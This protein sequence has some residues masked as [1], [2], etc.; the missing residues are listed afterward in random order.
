MERM[1]L[2]IDVGSTTAK[3]AL[4]DSDKRLRL[5]EYRRHFA[6]QA[7]CVRELLELVAAEFPEAHFKVAVCGSGAR[8]VAQQLG[9]DFVQEVVANSIAIKHLHPDARTAIE[10]GGQDAK[11]I[12]FHF[13]DASRQLIASD[14]RMNGVCAGGTGAFIDEIAQLLEIPVE[15]FNAYA[16]RTTRVHQ[17]SGRCGVFAKTD[18]QPLLNQGI[19]REE[20]AL[21]TLYAVAR[22][23]IGGLA[24]GTTIK[25]P[26]VFE[27][28]P[29]TFNPRLIQAFADL[30]HLDE[31]EVIVPEKP[32]V[33][34]AY[35][36]ALATEALL[37][38][39]AAWHSAGELP[40]RMR[41]R[42]DHAGARTDDA[43]RPF[44]E[45]DGERSDFFARQ[46]QPREIRN[47]PE[48]CKRLDVWVGIDSGSTTSKFVFLDRDGTPIYSYYSN[49]RGQPLRVLN[50]A[51]IAAREHATSCGTQFNILG[52]GTTGYGEELAA[53]AFHADHHTVETVA[54]ARAA[55]RY[56]PDATFVLDIG[57]QDMKAIFVNDGVITGITLNEACSSG[58]GAFIETFAHSLGVR[59]EDIAERAFRAAAPAQLGS[60]CTV[61][62]RSRVITEL[63]N[64]KSADD[65]LA[66]LCRSIIKNVFTKVIRL[67][68]LEALGERIVVQGGTFRNDAILRAMELH[69]GRNVTRAPYSELMGAIGVALLTM[70]KCAGT[71]PSSFIG[72]DNLETL[73]YH[74]ESGI[75][76]PFCANH[77][78]R[79]VVHF[80]DGTHYV[81]GN[82]C[83]RGEI[84]GD[85]NDRDVKQQAM[86]ATKRIM[87]VPN[88]IEERERL[89]FR[90]YAVEPLCGERGITIGIPRALD[91][92]N[93]LPFWRGLF[94]SL[95][96]GIRVS[97]KS[98]Y[99]LF[100]SALSTIPS[101]TVCFPAKLAHGHV[102]ALRQS[103]VDRI[104]TP[105]IISGLPRY[106]SLERDYP[107]AVLH[108]Y[109]LVLK[110]NTDTGIAHDRPAFVWKNRRMREKQLI[111]YFADT[112]GIDAPLVR[113]AITQADACQ[114]A[115]E[116]GLQE[117]ASQVIADVEAQ[118][119]FAVVMSMR[120][121]Q[122]DP[123]VNH[124]IGKY[125]VRL[126][127][128]VIPADA[129]PGLAQVELGDLQVRVRSNSQAT[130][131]A[132][133]KTVARNPHL[134]LA[135]IASFG[136]GHDA[137]VCDELERIVEAAGKQ[138]LILKL[139]ESDV[140]GP[141]RIRITSFVETVR[142]Q[143]RR[144]AAKSNGAGFHWPTFTHEDAKRR[145]VYVPN[146][147][148]GFSRVIGAVIGNSGVHIEVLPLAD[149]RAIELGKL[150]LHNDI[151]FPA[152]VNVGEFLRMVETD[153]PDPQRIALGMHQNCGT[154]R[155]GQYAMLAR[156]A[157]D[158]AGLEN[159]PIVTSG[160]ELRHLH[161]GF[162]IDARMQLQL[163]RAFAVLDALEDLRRST[164]PYERDRGTTEAAWN[165][166]LDALC[167]NVA[168]GRRAVYEVL[169]DAVETFNAIPLTGEAPRPTALV[170]GEIL[171]AVHPSSNYRLEAYLEKHGLEVIGTRLSDFFHSGFVVARAEAQRWFERKPWM[172]MLIDKTSDDLIVR[173]LGSAEEI[174]AGYA[175]YRPR[176]SAREIYATAS[177]WIDKIH[178]AGEGW[179]ILGEIL[180]AAEHGI[181]NFVV[182]QPFG[183]MPN[184]IFGRGLTRVVKEVHPHVQVLCLDFD[185]DTS[186]GNIEN[187]LQM[188]IMNAREPSGQ[189]QRRSWR[190]ADARPLARRGTGRAS[191]Y[192][193]Y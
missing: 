173:A 150:Y 6:E 61:F 192:C 136:C 120:A 178:S 52:V 3:I 65:I 18:I 154:C 38:D 113:A 110:N 16:E 4:V 187:R 148:V 91:T 42:V 128:P 118:G 82:R 24:Q 122:A 132:A 86:A 95:G 43:D 30:L 180:H 10:L 123:L 175:R 134:E 140:R 107:C 20:L 27:G 13:D 84:L 151:C 8:P 40:Q 145:T 170:L 59:V 62:M 119:S 15:E 188:L 12:F 67:H 174:M 23:T 161:P 46:Q 47:V 2:G 177:P 103:K 34:V 78:N 133:A 5:S 155:A 129:L 94:T 153:G 55:L 135:H 163:I 165:T 166:A 72:L 81:Q 137:V 89:V 41:R 167:A 37:R 116:E 74:E 11:V 32:E 1:L 35:G 48:G 76:C 156:K 142:Q 185:P 147:S 85:P 14:M 64:G 171:L 130:L 70:E 152:Q 45:T 114:R 96:F 191:E 19:A 124:F 158:H 17:V 100:E 117:R 126:G 143:R 101:D 106:D 39:K 157:L 79:T 99:E 139:D 77:C 108:G 54:H 50:E 60:R 90:N 131:Y 66:G 31:D 109:G 160:D 105:I 102:L 186:M 98:S 159:V 104:F 141:L 169:S 97:E 21:S 28:G 115:F 164:R 68:N 93:R 146:L 168:S 88:L 80:A 69:T 138:V 36:C 57:G 58:C 127:I 183:C 162:G 172:R 9:V 112:F 63:K 111:R 193:E 149:D 87:S 176:V 125:F 179:L 83:E 53:A 92:W 29:L 25:A 44:F 73:D 189:Y 49:N 71:S 75:P 121:Y 7:N 26:V 33:T 181:N 144:A 184:H 182:V 51:L 22:Q 190:R 56:D